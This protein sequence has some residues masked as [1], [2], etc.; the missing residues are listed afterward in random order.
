MKNVNAARKVTEGTYVSVNMHPLS[1]PLRSPDPSPTARL[2]LPPACCE[3]PVCK[4]IVPDLPSV[5]VPVALA[6]APLAPCRPDAEEEMV[7][8]P[9]DP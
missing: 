2:M 6:T 9:D 3:E 8:E 1:P 5:A 7:V 4:D